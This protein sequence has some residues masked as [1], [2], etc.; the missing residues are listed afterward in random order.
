M[1]LP[2]GPNLGLLLLSAVVETQGGKKIG[3]SE[4]HRMTS[5]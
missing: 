4:V 3:Q 2:R 1:L 5:D